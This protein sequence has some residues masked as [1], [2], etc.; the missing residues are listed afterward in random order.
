MVGRCSRVNMNS[1]RMKKKRNENGPTPPKQCATNKRV[2]MVFHP[3]ARLQRPSCARPPPAYGRPS[4]SRS[5]F[6]APQARLLRA[7][8]VWRGRA[9]KLAAEELELRRRHCALAPLPKQLTSRLARASCESRLALA[10]AE[11]T[12]CRLARVA[13]FKSPSD[14]DGVAW[15]ERAGELASARAASSAGRVGQAAEVVG[16][17]LPACQPAPSAAVPTNLNQ[18]R[19]RHNFQAAV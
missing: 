16:A 1:W 12:G 8:T 19:R 15:P 14:N 9:V 5:R 13:K 6:P 11:L 18:S 4:Q 17:S 3:P 10:R 7:D 2:V